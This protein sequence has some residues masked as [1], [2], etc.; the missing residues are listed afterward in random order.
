MV[1]KVEGKRYKITNRDSI[2]FGLYLSGCAILFA[3]T[4][5]LTHAYSSLFKWSGIEHS[6]WVS[7]VGGLFLYSL[8]LKRIFRKWLDKAV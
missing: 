7:I 4:Y 8:I 3:I 6:I 5:Y 2:V 1:K